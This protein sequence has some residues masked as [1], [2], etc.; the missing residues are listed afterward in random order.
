MIAKISYEAT[1]LREM[2]IEIVNKYFT[3]ERIAQ[4]IL[5]GVL[6]V[7]PGDAIVKKSTCEV[8]ADI[9]TDKHKEYLPITGFRLEE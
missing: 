8:V 2:T 9:V 7:I 5:L 6:E 3:T 4:E 1:E